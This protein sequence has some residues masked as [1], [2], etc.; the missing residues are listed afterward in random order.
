MYHSVAPEYT[1]SILAARD[2]CDLAEKELIL[3]R[4]VSSRL[5]GKFNMACSTLFGGY[6]MGMQDD[7]L[8]WDAGLASDV[9]LSN[10]KAESIFNASLEKRGTAFQK[11]MGK[12]TTLV[13]GEFLAVEVT[14]IVFAGTSGVKKPLPKEIEAEITALEEAEQRIG[15]SSTAKKSTVETEKKKEPL[16]YNDTGLNSL[17]RL[18]VKVWVPDGPE[19]QETP[20]T[21]LDEFEIWLEME[22]LQYCFVGM[23]IEAKVHIMNSGIIWIDSVTVSSNLSNWVEDLLTPMRKQAVQCSFYL[24]LDSPGGASEDDSD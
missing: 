8:T 7:T 2:V 6:Y 10:A 3:C 16:K 17:G 22:V 21:E 24:H 14:G 11:E 12:R 20:E 18:L 19:E 13:K 23:H 4:Q 1:A 5:P 15:E 9:G